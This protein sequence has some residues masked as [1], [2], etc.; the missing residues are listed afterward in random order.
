[1]KKLLAIIALMTAFSAQ[2]DT[3]KQSVEDCTAIANIYGQIA[4]L[5]QDGS[6][7]TEVL[8]VTPDFARN[9]VIHIY[10]NNT[11]YGSQEYQDSVVTD[12]K[13]SAMIN[14][15]KNYK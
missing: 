14:C 8:A 12:T 13:N 9:V 11:R 5:H 3:T 15:L 2:A 10:S 1:M 4:M 7:L 6:P